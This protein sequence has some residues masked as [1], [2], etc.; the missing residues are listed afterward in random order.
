M[1]TQA[2]SWLSTRWWA[3]SRACSSVPTEVTTTRT[4]GALTGL[5]TR[6]KVREGR[7]CVKR[8]LTNMRS[9]LRGDDSPR[10]RH[11]HRSRSP[12]R[13]SVGK[14]AH[15]DRAESGPDR[16]ARRVGPHGDPG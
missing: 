6:M 12:R 4:A 9:F 13:L 7:R 16:G 11:A 3:I 10:A 5:F 14:K 1:F 8:R 2:A 15:P